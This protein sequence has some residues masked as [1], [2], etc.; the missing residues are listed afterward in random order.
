[1]EAEGSIGAEVA[2]P[3]PLCGSEKRDRSAEASHGGSEN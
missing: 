2:G 3:Y 1:M